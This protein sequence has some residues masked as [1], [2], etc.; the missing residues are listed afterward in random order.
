[1]SVQQIPHFLLFLCFSLLSAFIFKTHAGL[2]L[3]LVPSES[4][5]FCI[6]SICL[7]LN[8]FGGKIVTKLLGTSFSHFKL[9]LSILILF[10]QHLTIFLK[11]LDII[12]LLL[13]TLHAHLSF[14]L[15]ILHKHFFKII[16][17][18]CSFVLHHASLV[19]HFLLKSLN[20][21]YFLQKLFLLLGSFTLFFFLELSV[22]T[23]FLKT[24]LFTLC[25]SFFH[26][27][28]TE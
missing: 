6:L 15:F 5:V 1:M 4:F 24:N 7:F 22:S 3:I 13:S 23:L 9:S 10:V 26:F 21:F 28:E 16:A 19:L 14:I 20:K 2:A 17:L 8:N 27:S 25:C 18:L 12:L 11:S